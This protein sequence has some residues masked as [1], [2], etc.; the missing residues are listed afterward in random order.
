MNK[1]SRSITRVQLL[2]GQSGFSLVEIMVALVISL[3]LAIGVGQVYVSN[4]QSYRLQ[5]A[6]SRLQENGRIALD[7]ISKDMRQAGY[8]GCAPRS[9]T[10]NHVAFAPPINVPAFS[11]TTSIIGNEYNSGTDWNPDLPTKLAAMSGTNAVIKGTDVVTIQFGESCGGAVTAVMGTAGASVTIA[12]TN[13]CGA[14]ASTSCGS[15]PG[16]CQTGDVF[17]ISN[18][19]NVDVFRVSSASGTGNSVIAHSDMANAS[20]NLGTTYDRQAEVMH[21]R[22]YSYFIR[23]GEGGE[24]ALWRLDN[25]AQLGG[26]NPSELVEGVED[27]EVL[28]GFDSTATADGVANQYLTASEVAGKDLNGDTV[29]DWNRVVSIRV[30]LTARSVGENAD[31]LA[32]ASRSYTFNGNSASDRRL[33]RTYSATIGIRNAGN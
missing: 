20:G 15:A 22:S 17:L 4:K 8:Q 30:T 2:C 21:F 26:D 33:V 19:R 9:V 32:P 13:T 24:P 16:D 11:A 25:T 23:L 1:V 7:I 31:N 3:L 27:M 12:T 29:A 6:Q 10:P 5:D 18:C 14:S 28:Y